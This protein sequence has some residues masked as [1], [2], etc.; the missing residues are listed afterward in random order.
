MMYQQELN[1]EKGHTYLKK[2]AVVLVLLLVFN[3]FLI[4]P[5]LAQKTSTYDG[6]IMTSIPPVHIIPITLNVDDGTKLVYYDAVKSATQ[7]WEQNLKKI[8]SK[9]NWRMTIDVGYKK[10]SGS[11]I[12]V[13]FHGCNDAGNGE[14]GST[15]AGLGKITSANP[16]KM[17]IWTC[18]NNKLFT[19]KDV[20]R[21]ATHEMGHAIG[22]GHTSDSKAIMTPAAIAGNAMGFTPQ[23]GKALLALYGMNGF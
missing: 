9:G 6:N 20:Y 23:I 14:R 13:Y 17:D 18:A 16:V 11:N 3:G 10:T 5:A 4:T 19:P 21:I 7:Y 15:T 22:L 12:Y 1:M 8:D 2:P